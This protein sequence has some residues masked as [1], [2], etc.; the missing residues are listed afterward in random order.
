MA[1]VDE[2]LSRVVDGEGQVAD[3]DVVRVCKEFNTTERIGTEAFAAFYSAL[4]TRQGRIV[5]TMILHY[6]CPECDQPYAS[7]QAVNADGTAHRRCP[8]CGVEW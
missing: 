3:C 1:S 5:H 7:A 6:K 2:I 4:P 8:Y